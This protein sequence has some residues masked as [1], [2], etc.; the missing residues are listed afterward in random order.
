MKRI[1]LTTG[2][3]GGHIYPALALA[4]RL[5]EEGY[6]VL[7]IGTCHRMEKDIVP[8]AGFE[9]IGLDVLPLNSFNSIIKMI[10]AIFLSRRILKEKKIDMVIGFGNYISIPTII[11][12]K[13]LSKDIYLQEQNVIMG[14]ANKYGYRIA[15]KVFLA[16]SKTLNYIPNKSKHKFI[17]TG[18][19]LR[20]EFYN[21]NK[22]RDREKLGIAKDEKVIL[23][24]GG[25]LGAKP[26]NEAIIKNIES[27]N[28]K[29]NLRFYWSTG[30]NLF[31]ETYSKIKN[32]KNIIL[33]PYFENVCEIM[34]A[35]D[36]VVCRA[37]ASTI[38]ELLELKKPSIMIPY[39]FVG[40][41]ENA[42]MLEYADATKTFT[43]EDA[44]NAIKEAL[45][46]IEQ[47]E[48]LNFMKKNIDT[49]NTGNAVENIIEIIKG[50]IAD[51]R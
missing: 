45:S 26:I 21:S 36:L 43:N 2:G 46:L 31:K 12:A 23:V 44:G 42:D 10:R 30:E 29:E 9:F 38:S 33:M 17:V 4:K 47:E 24:M 39:S 49:L 48:K 3:T 27:I 40:Q 5:K 11:A 13:L 35:S 25:S 1:V 18:N 15:K 7:F 14:L 8:K 37:G 41:K 16:Y 34:S 22:E 51:A 19:P 20:Q 28:N 6:E 32:L 50:D